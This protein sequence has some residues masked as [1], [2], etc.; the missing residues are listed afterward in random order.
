MHSHIH[1]DYLY[2]RV[3]APMSC[4]ITYP[5]HPLHTKDSHLGSQN[6]HPSTIPTASLCRSGPKP[7]HMDAS[8]HTGTV[9]RGV[10]AP[11]ALLLPYS[12]IYGPFPTLLAQQTPG[13]RRAFLFIFLPS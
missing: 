4:P 7:C 12:V 13:P 2:P 9:T 6:T 8:A 5:S 3:S 1:W 11:V 10:T